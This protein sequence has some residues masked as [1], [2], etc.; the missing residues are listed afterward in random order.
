M[1]RSQVADI[2][3]I[4]QALLKLFDGIDANNAERVARAFAADGVWERRERQFIGHADIIE[5]MR[6]RPAGRAI[7]HLISN[8]VVRTSDGSTASVSFK[9]LAFADDRPIKGVPSPMALPIALDLYAATLVF[10][11]R[12]WMVASLKGDRLFA[13]NS[14]TSLQKD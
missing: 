13:Y 11:E 14:Y 6:R 2:V 1:T 12:E 8:F 7:Q 4:E 9:V 5:E 10:R 3:L